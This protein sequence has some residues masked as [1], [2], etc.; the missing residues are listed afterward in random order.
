[1]EYET[2]L[3]EVDG[4]VGTLTLN[5]PKSVNAVN[6][7]MMEE[8]IDFWGQRQLDFDTSVIILTG[9][10]EKGFCAGFDMKDAT[11]GYSADGMTPENIY[12]N[13]S[14]FSGILKLMRTCPQPIIAA[15]H[16][17]AMGAGMSFAMASDVRLASR[18]A[19]FCAA[20]INIGVGG[21]DLASSYLLWRLVGIGKAA[22]MCYS[23]DRMPAEE[24]WRIGLVNHLH[25]REELMAQAGAVAQNF[26]YKS[27]FA[28]HLT[29]EALN[30]GLNAPS[31]D[32]ALMMEN[33]NQ[34]YMLTM[35]LMKYME[36]QQEGS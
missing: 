20:Y 11:E 28:L 6:R 10:G 34:S 2:L 8:L 14:R 36:Q 23:G 32:E 19:V 30:A 12:R 29:K 27:P 15:V 33:R 18:D 1:M 5:R 35:Q 25:E 16:G 21:A 9:A 22:E 13:Q 4:A 7:Q 3:Y 31:M 26:A 24:A 17:Y